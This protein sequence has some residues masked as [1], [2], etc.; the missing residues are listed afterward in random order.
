MKN[1]LLVG[2]GPCSTVC[3]AVCV[4]VCVSVCVCSSR[5][6]VAIW[7]RVVTVTAYWM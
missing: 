3:A 2:R 5:V 4:C 7:L 1:R 6:L